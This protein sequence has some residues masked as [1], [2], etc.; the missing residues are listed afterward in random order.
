MMRIALAILL[1]VHGVI[2]FPGFAKAFAYA[3]LPQLTTP[4]SRIMGLAWLTAGLLMLLSAAML[5]AWPRGWWIAGAIAVAISQAVAVSAWRDAWA[6]TIPNVVLLLAVT[7]GWLTEGPWSFRAQFARDATLG[8]AHRIDTPVVTGADLA[9]LPPPVRRYLHAT[10]V[11]GQPRV[12]NYHL[13]FRGRIRSA[14]DAA[15]MPFE[16]VQQSFTDPPTR[17]FL[18]RARMFGLPVEAFHR[19]AD[20]RATMQVKILG[21]IPI[22]NAAG[23]VMDQSETV[24]LFNDMCLLAPGTLLDSR[25]HW[26]P[27]DAHTV[28]ARFTNGTQRIAAM[29]FFDDDGLMTNF[30]SEDRSQLSPDGKSFT[31][32]RFSTPV[33]G[34]R[35][36]GAVRLPAHGEARYL[37]PD[38][39]FTYGE[40][41][42]QEATYNS[43]R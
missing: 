16:A 21:V 26:E 36:F 12:R 10:G 9:A 25:I 27:V 33:R 17:L 7:H 2:H 43:H 15:W 35:A 11:V 20:G 13:R 24:T 8:L 30:I 37:L 38:G 6:A 18:M 32:H 41:N 29:L 4:I 42:L 22:V 39:E 34:Y 5:L 28:S 14:P 40:F 19:F 31:Q 23:P 1:A 3:S